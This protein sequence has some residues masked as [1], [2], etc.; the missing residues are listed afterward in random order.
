MTSVGL[1]AFPTFSVGQKYYQMNL[2]FLQISRVKATVAVYE[3]NY[4]V[5]DHK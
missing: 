5:E 2:E 4:S 1:Q 3:K